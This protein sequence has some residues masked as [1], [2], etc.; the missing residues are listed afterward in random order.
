MTCL[1]VCAA[2]RPKSIGG[3]GSV[4]KSP[5]SASA[6]RRCARRRAGSASSSFSTG[7]TTSRVAQQADL[8]GL[9]VDLGADVVFLAVFGAA[10]LLD[11][12]LHRL[13]HF[14]ARRCPSRGRPCRRP[15]AVR[16][17]RRWRC[18]PSCFRRSSVLR[19]ARPVIGCRVIGAGQCVWPGLRWASASSSSV[20]TSLALGDRVERQAHLAGLG[21]KP[22]MV[23]VAPEQRP[24]NR[25]RPST[26]LV[27]LDRA[28][29][30]RRNGRNP[31]GGPAAGRCRA[32]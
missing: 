18:F 1:A 13:E 19:A 10:G 32:S 30:T 2:M 15:A 23:A 20:R 21:G 6:L 12:L 29:R 14:L 22:D 11:G 24:R 7:S 17:G 16:G 3:S 26:R 27:E 31:P 9:A 4:M 5:I 28:P 25:L 8:A